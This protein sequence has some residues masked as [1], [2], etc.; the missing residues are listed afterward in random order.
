MEQKKNT[1]SVNINDLKVIWRIIARNWFIPFI[2]VPI[3]YVIGYF[4]VY[5]LTSVYQASVELLKS[6]DTYYKDNLI[7]DQGFYGGGQSF[8]DNSNEIRIIKSFDL[9]KETV[10]KLKNQLQVSYY[11]VGRVRTT[12]QFSGTPFNVN[13]NAI[14]PNLNE[15]KIS[16]KIKNYD[17]YEIKYLSNG[18]EVTKQGLFGKEFIDVDFNMT[19]FRES[20]FNVKTAEQLSTLNYEI[21]VHNLD[22]L[23]YQYQQVLDVKNPDYT[24]IRYTI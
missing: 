5:K 16:F 2:I 14:N 24:N 9:M 6:N 3:L 12:E 8:I 7:T 11:L 23:I 15:S 19:V 10:G 18:L 20:N 21:I 22:N 1:A 17:E 13:V 4:Y